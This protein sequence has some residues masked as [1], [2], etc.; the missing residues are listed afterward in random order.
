MPSLSKRQPFSLSTDTGVQYPDHLMDRVVARIAPFFADGV[1]I[2]DSQSYAV[3]RQ[4]I[5]DYHPVTGKELQLAAQISALGMAVLTCLSAASEPGLP[6]ET[7]LRISDHAIKLSSISNR[8]SKLLDSRKQ[9]RGRGQAAKPETTQLDEAEFNTTMN[10]ARDYVA[11][12]RA[13]VEAHRVGTE[14]DSGSAPVRQPAVEATP[15]LP[16][17]IAEE[18]TAS[19]L[20]RRRSADKSWSKELS[21]LAS[22]QGL[23]RH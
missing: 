2:T 22:L 17:M 20:H 4:V 1:T 19:V 12:A 13:K 6:I 5:S 10:M 21:K 16:P 18:M 11:F 7:M 9:E 8:N 23:T 3:A 15:M 14:L